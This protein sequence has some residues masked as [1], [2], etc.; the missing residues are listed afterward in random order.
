MFFLKR[1]DLQMKCVHLRVLILE[2]IW[3]YM[4]NRCSIIHIHWKQLKFHPHGEFW[5]NLSL[6]IFCFSFHLQK[7]KRKSHK[8]DTKFN[9]DFVENA[10]FLPWFN[11]DSSL[12][13][14]IFWHLVIFV[15]DWSKKKKKMDDSK[16]RVHCHI[17]VSSRGV[18]MLLKVEGPK[19][20]KLFWAHFIWKTGG[21]QPYF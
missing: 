19:L 14:C 15:T 18:V 16:I 7:I 13:S 21:V 3:V 9:T 6:S 17:L 4:T 12:W 2:E 10:H 8:Y 11:K 5:K 1:K 20:P